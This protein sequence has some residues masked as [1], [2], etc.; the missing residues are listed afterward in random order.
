ML[1][2]CLRGSVEACYES[3]MR[4]K[5]VQCWYSNANPSYESKLYMFMSRGYVACNCYIMEWLIL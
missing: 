1:T 5:Y 2:F 4:E 3:A